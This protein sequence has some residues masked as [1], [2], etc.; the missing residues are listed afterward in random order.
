MELARFELATSW[1]RST[2]KSFPPVATLRDLSWLRGFRRPT[3]AVLRHAL[4][5]RNRLVVRWPRVRFRATRSFHDEDVAGQRRAGACDARG[6]P[7]C[8]EP[9]P[10][11]SLAD[12]LAARRPGTSRRLG[13][14]PRGGGG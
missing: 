2:R 9:R 14:V 7:R 4:A 11:R 6:E 10:R 1:V 3:F 12:P 5:T 13:V 8:A